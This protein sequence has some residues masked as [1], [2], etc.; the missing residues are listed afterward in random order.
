MFYSSFLWNA[1][2]LNKT[3]LFK[4]II[5][6]FPAFTSEKLHPIIKMFAEQIIVNYNITTWL[7]KTIEN[8]TLKTILFT[9]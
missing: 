6:I 9:T 3:T 8:T 5:E 7:R 1:F 2:L 4:K